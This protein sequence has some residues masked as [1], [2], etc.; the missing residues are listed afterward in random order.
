[1]VC[2][3]AKLREGRPILGTTQNGHETA[4]RLRYLIG[5]GYSPGMLIALIGLSRR[6]YFRHTRSSRV[7][8]R[9]ALKVQRVWRQ[10]EI[11]GES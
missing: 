11:E 1:M 2:Y 7:T 10:Q 8:L 6:S 5:E 9:T 4:I 3:R